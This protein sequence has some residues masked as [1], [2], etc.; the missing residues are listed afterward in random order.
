MTTSHPTNMDTTPRDPHLPPPAVCDWLLEQ[1]W[2]EMIPMAGIQYYGSTPHGM[3]QSKLYEYQQAHPAIG[4]DQGGRILLP[5]EALDGLRKDAAARS[6][7]ALQ[8]SHPSAICS[9]TIPVWRLVAVTGLRAAAQE[10]GRNERWH[11]AGE[12]L[13]DLASSVEAL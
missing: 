5:A 1:D 8:S 7:G 6:A 3:S 11:Q 10:A 4:A 13:F 9:E 2:S 12:A